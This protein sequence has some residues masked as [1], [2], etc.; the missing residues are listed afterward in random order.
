MENDFL[1]FS[2]EAEIIKAIN[3][4]KILY[5]N[6]IQKMTS[7]LIK[8]ERNF[9]ITPQAIYIFHNKKLKKSIKYE[10]IKAITFSTIS[11]EF[12]IHRK[13]E[14]DYHYLCPDKIKLI[15]SIIKA[16]EKYIKNPIILCEIN[17]KSLKPYATTKKEKKKDINA[18]RMDENKII[19]TQTFLIDNDNNKIISRSQTVT[20]NNIL[21]NAKNLRSNTININNINMDMDIIYE[22]NNINIIFA[23]NEF[24]NDKNKFNENDIKY[25]KVIGRGKIGKIYLVNN[26]LDKKYYAVKSIDKNILGEYNKDKIEKILNKLNFDF[27]TNIMFCYETKERIYFFF[28]YVQNEDLFSHINF[29]KK[30]SKEKIINEEKIK[31]FIASIILALEY[32]HK[33]EII[34]RNIT[35]KN[36]LINKD[37]YIKLTPFSLENIFKI[38]NDI[39]NKLE[40]SEYSSPEILNNKE[41]NISSDFWNLGIII[42]EMIYNITP[43]YSL[44]SNNLIEVINNNE[45]KFPKNFE[46]SENLKDLIEKLLKK[47]LEERL[48]FDGDFTQIKNHDFFN[49]FNFDDLINKKMESPYKPKFE[50]DLQSN[51]FEEK[52]KYEDLIKAEFN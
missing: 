35:P 25:M 39:I 46:I 40:K 17:E 34:Y 36:I 13:N 6:K 12:I 5:S 7:F 15:C 4:E 3:S 29:Y 28:E 48:G 1:S 11:N 50:E 9:I 47:N 16:Y 38:K 51:T 41:E 27:I 14:Y 20:N 43:F 42:Y 26:I 2:K 21:S 33:N 23:K 31:F 30:L 52:Y 44:D 10:D 8:Q 49:N 32:L 18:S 45:I 24:I 19:D 37:G 22:E